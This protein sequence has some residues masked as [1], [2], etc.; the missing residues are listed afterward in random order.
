MN[1]ELAG[2]FGKLHQRIDVIEAKL[3]GKA[4]RDQLNRVHDSLDGIAKRL[5]TYEQERVVTN[6][7]VDRQAGWIGQL[8]EAT[9]T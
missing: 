3:N 5:E 1:E 4:D 9:K 8:A 2:F 7:R 6:R